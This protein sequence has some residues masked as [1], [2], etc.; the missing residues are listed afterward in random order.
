MGPGSPLLAAVLAWQLSSGEPGPP[1]PGLSL[2]SEEPCP[3]PARSGDPGSS[4][5]IA[6]V[7][8]ELR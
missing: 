8:W 2:S 1:I 7:F 5:A 6:T 3:V 4:P